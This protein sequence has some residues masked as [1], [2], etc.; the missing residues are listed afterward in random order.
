ML[1][2]SAIVHL[3]IVFFHLL[4]RRS[5]DIAVMMYIIH[6]S[7]SLMCLVKPDASY[8]RTDSTI[9]IEYSALTISDIQTIW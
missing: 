2:P 7:R 3:G 8:H 5:L 6:Q 4:S 9:Q 1:S